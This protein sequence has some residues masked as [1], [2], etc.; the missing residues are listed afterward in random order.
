MLLSIVLVLLLAARLAAPYYVERLID[1]RLNQ[2]PGF[3]G[4][5]TGIGLHIWRGAYRIDGM[6]IEKGNGRVNEPFFAA[7]QIDF[8][9]AWSQI[10]R[11]RFVS[12]IFITNGRLNF[13]RGNSEETSQLS[14][15]K[16]GWQDVINDLFPIDITFL[17][18]RGGV[19]RFLDATHSPKVDIA[20]HDLDVSATGLQNRPDSSGD[21]YPAKI[22]VS[23]VTLGGG[24]LHLFTKLEPLAD[25]PHFVLAMELKN[26][27]MPALNEF[28]KAYA[29]VEVSQGRFEAFS[30]MAMEDGHYEGYVK[31]FLA[32]V[33]FSDP[34]KEK[35][36]PWNALWT[37]LVSGAAELAKNKD[38]GE[39]ATRIPFSGEADQ[40]D[41]HLWKSIENGLHH[42]FVR[43]LS[44]GFE[45]TTNP[46]KVGTGPGTP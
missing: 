22:H 11:G 12:R 28:L 17:D 8:S 21:P 2:I 44:Q 36:S 13:V 14:S 33:T 24:E 4:H 1:R 46:D 18:I 38:T 31:P 30:Q 45:G 40:M 9:I 37:A 35:S 25:K 39:V 5:V 23:G 29:N 26:V 43:A 34:D 3:S 20:I 10:F 27:S 16:K 19:L 15:D 42:G 7:D 32:N 6:E 41:I